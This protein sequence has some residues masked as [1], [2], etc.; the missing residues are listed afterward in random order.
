M[1][2]IQADAPPA[3]PT[4]T[5]EEILAHLE[6]IQE[7]LERAR[8]VK[9]ADA[10]RKSLLNAAKVLVPASPSPRSFLSV[11]HEAGADG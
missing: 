10:K 6:G 1:Q 3:P 11:R 5:E 8:A 2:R 9:A 7:E 4:R